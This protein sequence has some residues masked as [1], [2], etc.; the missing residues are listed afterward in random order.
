MLIERPCQARFNGLYILT[1]YSFEAC[2]CNV[3]VTVSIECRNGRRRDGATP[4]TGMP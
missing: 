3:Q 4:G 1:C 2:S